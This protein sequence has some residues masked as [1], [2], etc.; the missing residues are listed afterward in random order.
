M[1]RTYLEGLIA[2]LCGK[3]VLHVVSTTQQAKDTMR[4]WRQEAPQS[5]QCHLTF[6]FNNLR[7][8]AKSGGGQVLLHVRS[9]DRHKIEG[10]ELDWCVYDELVESMPD[11]LANYFASRLR[12]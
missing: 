8:R 4:R 3:R 6:D 5:I 10:I 7:V 1:K 9:Q 11:E 12:K 2:A